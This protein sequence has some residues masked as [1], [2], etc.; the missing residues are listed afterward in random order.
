ML[1]TVTEAWQTLV[2]PVGD[3][4]GPLS[5]LLLVL[6]V[7]TG[8]ADA[9]SYLVLGHVFVANMTGNVVLLALGLAGAK[10]FA[11]A[12]PVVALAA[13]SLGA[14]A[15]G[16]LVAQVGEHRA[17]A[18]AVTAAC[19]AALVGMAWAVGAAVGNPGSGAARYVLVMLLALS[20]GMQTGTARWLAVPD[21]ITT[22]VTRTIAGA[23]FDSRVAGGRN[24]HVGRRGLAV[25]ALFGGAVTGAFLVLHVNWWLALVAAL[26]LLL[27][28]M[29]IAGQLSRQHRGWDRPD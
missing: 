11:V 3:R 25:A 5:T 14:A 9:F 21:L 18:L 29:V 2:P 12:G 19:E 28:V 6:T 16:R 26:A 17:R 13:F 1:T 20:S 22:V 7:V 15:S 4:H 27:A 8:L 23:A 24:S 10:G